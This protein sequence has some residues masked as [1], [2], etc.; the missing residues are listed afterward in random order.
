[1]FMGLGFY[2]Y[3]LED[4]KKGSDRKAIPEGKL[5]HC[6]EHQVQIAWRGTSAPPPF[7]SAALP[8]FPIFHSEPFFH[9]FLKSAI[10][11]LF[12][13]SMFHFLKLLEF[14]ENKAFFIFRSPRPEIV[15]LN[16]LLLNN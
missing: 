4:E 9:W 7:H 6:L 14:L 12:S 15:C 1:M 3:V 10:D 11:I 13:L 16:K 5:L 2:L 8:V